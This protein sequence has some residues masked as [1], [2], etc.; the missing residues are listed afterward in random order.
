MEE[1]RRPHQILPASEPELLGFDARRRSRRTRRLKGPALVGS[2]VL[3]LGLIT[4][5][6]CGAPEIDDTLPPIAAGPPEAGEVGDAASQELTA[7]IEASETAAVEVEEPVL[8]DAPYGEPEA[9]QEVVEVTPEAAPVGAPDTAQE[10]AAAPR[11]IELGPVLAG[12]EREV[13]PETDVPAAAAAAEPETLAAAPVAEPLPAP[14]PPAASA[15]KAPLTPEARKALSGAYTLQLVSVRS[16]ED[17]LRHWGTLKGKH[18]HL[19]EGLSP[20]VQRADLGAKGV[21]HRLRVGPFADRESAA[22]ACEALQMRGGSC[23]VVR[24]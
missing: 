13:A 2:G 4:W 18:P 24:N 17:A 23:L 12:G 22:S 21:Y 6:T 16:S 9:A 3:V 8:V 7:G 1:K 10:A 14:A 5:S 15:P 19:L 11:E 20:S